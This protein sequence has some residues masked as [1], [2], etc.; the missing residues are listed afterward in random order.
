MTLLRTTGATANS[1][2]VVRGA[3]V[4]TKVNID[5]HPVSVGTFGNYNTNYAIATI[6]DQ[7]EVL[8]GTGLN[9]PTA[10]ESAFGTVNLRTRDFSPTNYLDVQGGL[11]SFTGSV[12]NVFGNVN[13][14]GGKLSL[15]GGRA[16]S[17]Y[18]GPYDSYIANRIGLT[19]PFAQG[20]GQAPFLTGLV[21]WQ[22][23]LSNRYNLDGEL[24]KARYRFSNSTSITAEF[25][26][27]QGQYYPQGGSYATARP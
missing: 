24:A 8:K 17:G 21:Q 11:D 22:G 25:L 7:V 20:T 18:R 1:F 15:L 3:D 13:L 23:D 16:F 6:F 10:G 14:L 5:G 26:G 12:Y 4:E 19:T 2:F 27:L 9:G